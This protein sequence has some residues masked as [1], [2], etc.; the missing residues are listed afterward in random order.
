VLALCQ[1]PPG[2]PMALICTRLAPYYK[3]ARQPLKR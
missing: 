2:G 3:G 1:G